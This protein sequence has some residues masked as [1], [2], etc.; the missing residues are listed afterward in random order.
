MTG[1]PTGGGWGIPRGLSLRLFSQRS[2]GTGRAFL[3]GD[4]SAPAVLPAS[5]AAAPPTA[6]SLSTDPDRDR[7][8]DRSLRYNPVAQLRGPGPGTTPPPQYLH[9]ARPPRRQ[10]A[11]QPRR[12]LRACALRP[13]PCP[14]PRARPRPL[15]PA[16]PAT[17]LS[18]PLSPP[19]PVP[20]LTSAALV[21]RAEEGRQGAPRRGNQPPA[22]AFPPP[23]LAGRRL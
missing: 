21:R 7:D 1:S 22:V 23:A 10:A 3:P 19:R 18:L 15:A 14:A 17:P 8:R 11:S 16:T 2:L 12:A 6:S 20:V 9:P 13:A 5:A 4:T